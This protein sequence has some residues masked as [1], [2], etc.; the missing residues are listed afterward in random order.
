[1]KKLRYQQGKKCPSYTHEG[2]FEANNETLIYFERDLNRCAQC[3]AYENPALPSFQEDLLQIARIILWKKGPLFDPNHETKASFRTYILPWICGELAKAKKREVQH[4]Q[5]FMP[6]SSE[7]NFPYEGAEI[8]SEP[9]ERIISCTVDPHS[10]FVDK[11]IWEMWNADFEKH[12]PELLQCLTNR[13]E[14][15][16]TLIR[17][18]MKQ[19]DIAETLALSKPR[20]SQLLKQVERKLSRECQNL[21]LIE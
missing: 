19:C 15:I 2:I 3:I 12:L 13:E 8:K 9:Q 17:V 16:F 18:N 11:L 20:V 7:G 1:M 21:G 10:N 5:R 4:C 14:Q 6:P